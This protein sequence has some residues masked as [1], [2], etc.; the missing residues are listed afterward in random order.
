M[1]REFPRSARRSRNLLSHENELECG[2]LSSLAQDFI[3]D[4]LERAKL[5]VR[6]GFLSSLAQDFIEDGSAGRIVLVPA[7]IPEFSSSGL[8]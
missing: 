1:V 5:V 6:L 4:C 8:H 7:C 2:L 3:E